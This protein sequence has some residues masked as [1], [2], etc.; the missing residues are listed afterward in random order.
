MFLSHAANAIV[1]LMILNMTMFISAIPSNFENTKKSMK[2]NMNKTSVLG[3]IDDYDDNFSN[4]TAVARLLN[5]DE[6]EG[7]DLDEDRDGNAEDKSDSRDG[8]DS[9]DGHTNHNS[10]SKRN[11]LW[12][13]I[14]IAS[15][16]VNLATWVDQILVFLPS[17]L[18]N[19][20]PIT[21]P[22][23][24]EQLIL[25][26][27]A[28]GALLATCAFF[29]IPEALRL[30]ASDEDQTGKSDAA[31]KS[32]TSFFFCLLLIVKFVITLLVGY[33]MPTFLKTLVPGSSS[34]EEE[35]IERTMKYEEG[36]LDKVKIQSSCF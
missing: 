14:I 30:L 5:V 24:F 9:R 8:D 4:D 36:M 20:K 13:H 34:L 12:R 17:F 7:N 16:L 2:V 3:L 29:L 6:T 18:D 23:L 11:K 32:R 10:Q 31:S 27:F 1:A 33:F 22:A 19:A 25:P 35:C 21:I 26:S 15:L 28:S